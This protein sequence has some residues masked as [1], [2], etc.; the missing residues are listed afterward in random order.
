MIKTIAP[1]MVPVLVVLFFQMKGGSTGE[2]GLVGFLGMLLGRRTKGD[3]EG[4][5]IT[6]KTSVLSIVN[7]FLSNEGQQQR[8]GHVQSRS[9]REPSIPLPH[10]Y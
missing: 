9:R 3:A 1:M 4:I 5:I 6:S 7:L 2:G 10:S 8:Y